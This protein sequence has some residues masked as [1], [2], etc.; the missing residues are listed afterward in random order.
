MIYGHEVRDDLSS[1]CPLFIS[2]RH[3]TAVAISEMSDDRRQSPVST[4]LHAYHGHYSRT[5]N[6]KTSVWI[7][8]LLLM[9][10]VIYV[11]CIT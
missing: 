3:D 6:Q 10:D 4:V 8:V 2:S 7:F 1:V 9:N 5:H 11:V